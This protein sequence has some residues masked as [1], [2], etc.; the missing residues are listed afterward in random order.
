MSR[1]KNIEA[2]L[3]RAEKSVV[4]LKADYDAA[5]KAKHI[6]EDI[7]IDI[8]NIFENLR[9]ALDYLAHEISEHLANL[10]PTRLYFPIRKTAGEFDQ[11]MAK[12]YPGVKENHPQVYA[13]LKKAQP[14]NDPWLGQFNALNNNNKHQYLVE[15]TRTESRHVTVTSP[16]GGGRVSWGPGVTFG[17]GVI[18]MGVP[19]DSRNQLPVP[20]KQVNTEIT[21]W[22]DFKFKD[23]GVS[24]IPFIRESIRRVGALHEQ[25]S[26]HISS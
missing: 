5:L 18:V 8:K 21:I 19:I 2:L 3:L 6:S 11:T 4:P 23:N 17:S 16:T 26:K 13:I 25:V 15:Q 22:V 24:V 1:R 7:K 14:F 20:N 10:Q 9:S 12:D